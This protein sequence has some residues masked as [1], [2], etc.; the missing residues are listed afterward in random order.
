LF[1]QT[2]RAGIEQ[3]VKSSH[4]RQLHVL[5][6]GG[7]G[8]GVEVRCTAIMIPATSQLV[9]PSVCCGFATT[10]EDTNNANAK[11]QTIV[12]MHAFFRPKVT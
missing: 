8:V 5:S 10:D 12:F 9:P 11:R 6:G 3:H 4:C 2:D 7:V 1:L